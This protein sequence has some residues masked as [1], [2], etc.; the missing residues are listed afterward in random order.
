MKEST[1]MSQRGF[2]L[3]ELMITVAI[4]AILAAVAYPSYTSHVVKSNRAE[5]KT[6][7]MSVAQQ[8][9]RCATTYGT[10]NNASC[11]TVGNITSGNSIAS[12]TNKYHVSATTLTATTFTLSAQ[13]Q[14]AQAS[15]D[16][17]CGT[18][19]LNHAGVK[20]EGGTA[21]SW[22]ECW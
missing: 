16:T 3:T 13:P 18:L 8:L 20:G 4:I 15:N 11:A 10:Y 5:G 14:G 6:T 9:E 1:Q 19:T 7:L 21:T 17:K 12:E 2:T 22:Q